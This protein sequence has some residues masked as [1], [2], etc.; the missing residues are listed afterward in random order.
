MLDISILAQDKVLK[1][2]GAREEFLSSEVSIYHKTDGVKLT[3][4][5]IQ[6]SGNLSDYIFQYKGNVLYPGEYDYETPFK[7]KRDSIG[8]SQFGLVFNHFNKLGKNSIPVGTELFIEYLLKKPTLSS[9]YNDTNKMVLIGYSKCTWDVSFAKLKTK[10]GKMLIQKR[11]TYARELNID[12]PLKLFQGVLG[13]ERSFESSI[14]YKG[15]KDEYNKRKN[16]FNW[17]DQEL[18]IKDIQDMLL[19][20]D[21][22]YGGK[23]EGVVIYVY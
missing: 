20:V 12:S 21:S 16:S 22:K 15:L 10:P 17:G 23:E 5:K 7:I 11:S 19:Q 18:L 3:V 4:V 6:D 8:S 2:K 13:N 1:N 9:Q 14:L